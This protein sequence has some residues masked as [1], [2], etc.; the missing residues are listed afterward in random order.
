MYYHRTFNVT[1]S[2]NS[3]TASTFLP[4]SK[5]EFSW[6][7]IHEYFLI[8]CFDRTF[9]MSLPKHEF[10]YK[11]HNFFLLVSNLLLKPIWKPWFFLHKHIWDV[12]LAYRKWSV[13]LIFISQLKPVLEFVLWLVNLNWLANRIVSG[14]TGSIVLSKLFASFKLTLKEDIYFV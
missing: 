14:F 10:D 6:L 9:F 8:G 2:C 4:S 13:V 1:F 5:W 7:D 3:M 12:Y 11:Q